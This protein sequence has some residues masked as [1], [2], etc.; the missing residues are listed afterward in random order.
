MSIRQHSLTMATV[1]LV[2]AGIA[3][4]IAQVPAERPKLSPP[5]PVPV[6]RTAAA[7]PPTARDILNG[8]ALLDLKTGQRTRLRALDATWATES[9]AAQAQLDAAVAE[10]S[11][12]MDEA[13]ARGRTSLQDLQRRS[14]EMS[15]LSAALRERRQRHTETAAA[16]LT[17]WQRT[18]LEQLMRPVASGGS[19]ET[20]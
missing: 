15:E 19:D 4:A 7:L 12:F 13:R 8:G 11:R 1:A 9:A 6:R 2:I 5:E 14:A 16:I 20:R 10:F 17:D 3:W 18:R